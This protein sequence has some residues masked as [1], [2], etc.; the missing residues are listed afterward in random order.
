MH[1]R[2]SFWAPALLTVIGMAGC[3]SPRNHSTYPDQTPETRAQFQAIERDS[4]RRRTALHE[5]HRR[6]IAVVEFE[7]MQVSDRAKQER[8]R[9]AL[10]GQAEI[11]ARQAHQRD[12]TAATAREIEQLRRGTGGGTPTEVAAQ[13]ATAERALAETVAAD[14]RAID[15]S[16]AGIDARVMKADQDEVRQMAVHARRRSVIDRKTREDDLAIASDISTRMDEAG[17]RSAQRMSDAQSKARDTT[18]ADM[19]LDVAVRADLADQGGKAQGVTVESRQ[20]VVTLTGTVANE[21]DR[22]RIVER[23]AQVGGVGRVDDRLSLR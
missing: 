1:H 22:R 4:T 2:L 6:Q 15:V 9:V 10:A 21:V 14:Q 8:E 7:E 5:E 20:G 11:Q 13:I 17:A 3:G 12:V 16:Q 18:E 23:T 19:N